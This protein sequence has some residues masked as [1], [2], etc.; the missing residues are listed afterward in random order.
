MSDL[1][2]E[3]PMNSTKPIFFISKEQWVEKRVQALGLALINLLL[4]PQKHGKITFS[5]INMVQ[6]LFLGIN[7]M[8]PTLVPLIIADI[9]MAATECQKK[10]GFFYG[11]N[12]I[13]QIWAMEHL[14][15]RMLNP[16]GSCLPAEKWIEAH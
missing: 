1:V 3:G 8:T 11:S 7:G 9:F 14:A 16:L 10:R 4:F 6:S 13:L 2:K 12:L 5:T 15:K